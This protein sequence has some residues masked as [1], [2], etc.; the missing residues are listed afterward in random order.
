MATRH[1]SLNGPSGGAAAVAAAIQTG[2][3]APL[4]WKTINE[5]VA[6]I[7]SKTNLF[8]DL[9]YHETVMPAKEAAAVAITQLAPEQGEELSAAAADGGAVDAAEG[10]AGTAGAGA[11]A[12]GAAAGDAAAGGA[13]LAAQAP[14]VALAP[15]EAEGPE[16]GDAD[17]AVGNIWPILQALERP[18]DLLPSA[19]SGSRDMLR[20]GSKQPEHDGGGDAS[21]GALDLEGDDDGTEFKV[22]SGNE[23]VGW[24][25][26]ARSG[27]GIGSGSCGGHLG[28]EVDEDE[29]SGLVD[30]E[31]EGVWAS[32]GGEGA[33][34]RVGSGG[35]GNGVHAAGMDVTR[36]S[37]GSIFGDRTASS[38]GDDVS[39][40]GDILS[41]LG[42]H[43]IY[44]LGYARGGFGGGYSA[45]RGGRLRSGSGG[46]GAQGQGRGW[47]GA[48]G[49]GQGGVDL[50]GGRGVVGMVNRRGAAAGAAAASADRMR[51]IQMQQL[52]LQL[53]AQQQRA[54]QRV[55]QVAGAPGAMEEEESAHLSFTQEQVIDPM[56][57]YSISTMVRRVSCL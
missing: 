30:D 35:G 7:V 9:G 45:A 32:E 56:M 40:G 18:S 53:Q 50:G 52:Q 22:V 15:A 29:G 3:S 10:A 44:G 4:P 8:C 20:S 21:A 39:S 17:A 41:E 25:E 34:A 49:A 14:T 13:V 57:E 28:D 19:T 33:G 37:A 27:N 42:L 16:E 36:P 46:V 23:V 1:G 2:G 5:A 11:A 54:Q 6:E 24:K 48:Y 26:V 43:H 38:T 31:E 47:V 12:A 51:M 55:V